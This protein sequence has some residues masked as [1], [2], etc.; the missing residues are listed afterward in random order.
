MIAADPARLIDESMTVS[1]FGGER[2]IWVK[3][4]GSDKAFVESVK[5]IAQQELQ[6]VTIIIEADDLKT[7]SA[8]RIAC[9]NAASIMALPCYSDSERDMD[10]LINSELARFNLTIA[11]DARAFL[12]KNLGGDRLASRSEL[13]KLALYAMGARQ[14][15]LS[16]VIASIGDASNTSLDELT[17]SVMVGNVSQFDS[18][19]AKVK[20][21]TNM[22]TILIMCARQVAVFLEYRAK[23]ER[24][25]KTASAF[26][27][28]VKPAIFFAR[29]PV[30]ERIL[31]QTNGA[32]FLRYLEKIHTASLES[33]QF[34]HLAS[35]ICHRTLLSLCLEQSKKK[36]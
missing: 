6:G 4:A 26:V 19:F 35:E 28:S 15:T 13:Q 36:S 34:T 11:P 3:N 18:L 2:L 12:K 7:S 27:G 23:M 30:V 10:P 31:A 33:R 5:M 1:L 8:L 24:E 17:D 9:E 25:G 14:V 32:T 20:N 21:H 29:K 16:D 22:Q